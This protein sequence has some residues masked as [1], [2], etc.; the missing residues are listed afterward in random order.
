MSPELSEEMEAVGDVGGC[1]SS[2]VEERGVWRSHEAMP[3]RRR[4]EGGMLVVEGEG[5][6]LSCLTDS[7]SEESTE[8]MEERG[9]PGES[10]EVMMEDRTIT[11]QWVF[12]SIL[13]YYCKMNCD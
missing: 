8:S 3:V 13:Y 7:W 12:I 6:R 9:D 4:F 1:I 5:A 10:L 11:K 2:W